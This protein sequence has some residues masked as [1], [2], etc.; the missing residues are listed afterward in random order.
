[1]A[2]LVYVCGFFLWWY[3]YGNL[4]FTKVTR[5]AVIGS[6]LWPIALPILLIRLA[7]GWWLMLES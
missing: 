1:M 7:I 6:L 3:A 5:R 4:G 2:A